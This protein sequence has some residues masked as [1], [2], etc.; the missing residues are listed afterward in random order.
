MTEPKLSRAK[1]KKYLA[2]ALLLGF[3]A[4]VSY[5][6]L[7]VP[8]HPKEIVMRQNFIPGQWIYVVQNP[9]DTSEPKTLN[10]Y[11]DDY[12]S[13]NEVMKVRLG[14]KRP[15]LISDT[16]LKDV[17]IRR[18]ANGLKVQIKGAVEDYH[19]DLYLADGD[20]YTT[21]RVSLEQVETRAPLPS[22]R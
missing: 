5:A 16:E 2:W 7:N 21:F 22:G 10:F 4:V 14:K 15:F 3:V 17:V 12:D 18:V 9:R 1:R 20:T 8:E 6:F 11:V 13:S 19:S